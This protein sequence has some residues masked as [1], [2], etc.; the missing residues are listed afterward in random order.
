MAIS[1]DYDVVPFLITIPKDDT[2]F[3]IGTQY[4][5]DVN[6]FWDLL[7]DY[8][9][10]D[11]SM[12]HPLMY[13]R[14]PATSSTPSITE[15]DLAY[16]RLQF[17]DGLYSVNII[18][19]NTNIREVEIKNQVSVNTNNTTGFIDAQF[20]QHSTF[21]GSVHLK[22]SGGNPGVLYP[23][24]TPSQ[25]VNNLPDAK[26]IAINQGLTHISVEG[27]F[28]FDAADSLDGYVMEG[29]SSSQ[30][31]IVLTPAA[32]IT[33]CIFRTATI[34]GSLDGGCD[35]SNC[36]I[37]SLDYIDGTLLD[38]FLTDGTITLSGAQANFLRCGSAVAGGAITD[39]PTL[40]LGGTGTKLVIRDYQGGIKLINHNVG[41]DSTSIDMSS[42]QVV[43]DSTISS[44]TF[45]IR[46]IAD[47]TDNSSGTAIIN[48]DTLT[49]KV[50][51]L[52]TRLDLDVNVP[53]TYQ[54]D[55]TA[56]TNSE[57]TLTNTDNLNGTH[58]VQRS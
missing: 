19:G 35:A 34:T 23:L 43:L 36:I 10:S 50:D 9:D 47:V 37:G 44:G 49:A 24:G 26:Q 18:N 31:T 13:T 33:N 11:E 39:T 56:I 48:D 53:N 21:G 54:D 3:D 20:L 42:G 27:T 38:C 58:T 57:F 45:T 8:S 2:T 1:V 7:A 5:M 22:Q 55:K 46:G 6:V 40:D 15:I 29:E 30:A 16:Y 17:E 25:P 14:I 4:Y 32:L 41:T 28:V 51:E 52:R 12:P